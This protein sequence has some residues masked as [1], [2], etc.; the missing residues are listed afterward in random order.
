MRNPK[1]MPKPQGTGD[2]ELFN[3]KEDP[4]ELKDLSKKYPQK[5]KELVEQWEQYRK[6]NGVLD[7]TSKWV[8]E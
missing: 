4:A 1:L 6:E 8:S 5:L 7:V 3:I 2:W